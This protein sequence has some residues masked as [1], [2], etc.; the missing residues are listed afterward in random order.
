MIQTGQSWPPFSEPYLQSNQDQNAAPQELRLSIPFFLHRLTSKL[1]EAIEHIS[2]FFQSQERRLDNKLRTEPSE[3]HEEISK[4]LIPSNEHRGILT[5]LEQL[6]DAI[7]REC[8]RLGSVFAAGTYGTVG[9]IP[10]AR[11]GSSPI[12]FQPDWALLDLDPSYLTAESE[13]KLQDSPWYAWRNRLHTGSWHVLQRE[14]QGDFRDDPHHCSHFCIDD[15]ASART[16]DRLYR[17]SGVSTLCQPN[18]SCTV[19]KEGA[20]TG[21]TAGSTVGALAVIP[22]R[23]PGQ[24]S[25][26]LWSTEVVVVDRKGS[27]PFSRRGDSGAAVFDADCRVVG[28]LVR[29]VVPTVDAD[30][31]SGSDPDDD[32]ETKEARQLAVVR[33]RFKELVKDSTSDSCLQWLTGKVQHYWGEELTFVTPIEPIL[34]DIYNVTGQRAEIA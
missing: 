27:S 11:L 28:L 31:L 3:K 26:A 9:D 32:E 10:L 2:K 24:A 13:T 33:Q 18:T 19:F 29:G 30:T 21:F 15:P 22:T 4:K 7:P 1:D 34:E 20:V 16:I 23:S 8:P 5:K 14:W 6:R 25:K 12:S 17:L